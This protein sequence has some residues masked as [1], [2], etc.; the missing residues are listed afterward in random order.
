VTVN[1]SRSDGLSGF[2][3]RIIRGRVRTEV[4]DGAMAALRSTKKFLERPR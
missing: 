3:G 4:K 1:R 2:L